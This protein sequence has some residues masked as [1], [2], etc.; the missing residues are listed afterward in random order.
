MD[1]L[2]IIN[3]SA[4]LTSRSFIFREIW[5]VDRKNLF[6]I[7]DIDYKRNQINKNREQREHIINTRLTAIQYFAYCA[8]IFGDRETIEPLNHTTWAHPP[9]PVLLLLFCWII[10]NLASL[11]VIRA[12]GRQITRIVRRLSSV[13]S[14]LIFRAFFFCGRNEINAA[15]WGQ[16]PGVK[17]QTMLYYIIYKLTVIKYLLKYFFNPAK[18]FWSS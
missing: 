17:K 8:R 16:S 2:A 11:D 4:L 3:N 1:K 18:L 12:R 5:N 10:V 9:F 7:S 15:R 14:L 13:T 6:L